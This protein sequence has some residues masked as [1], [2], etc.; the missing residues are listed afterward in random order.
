MW[1]NYLLLKSKKY[2]F[3]N[4]K[5]RLHVFEEPLVSLRH[6]SFE[7]FLESLLD[8][9]GERPAHPAT[10]VASLCLTPALK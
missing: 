1:F 6:E 7:T 8:Y 5:K 10:V 9:A 4:S 2:K 3:Q